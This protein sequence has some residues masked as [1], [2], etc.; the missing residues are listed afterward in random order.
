MFNTKSGGSAETMR[1]HTPQKNGAKR[2]PRVG[3]VVDHDAAAVLTLTSNTSKAMGAV[4]VDCGG[5]VMSG[6]RQR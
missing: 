2:Q 4:D 1:A 5:G 6:Q 3:V